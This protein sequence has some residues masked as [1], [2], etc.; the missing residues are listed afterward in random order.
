[1]RYLPIA[2]REGRD[3]EAKK[4]AI[5]RA[6]IYKCSQRR[7][8]E[9]AHPQHI[10]D[11]QFAERLCLDCKAR[12][13][14]HAPRCDSES[15]TTILV[16]SVGGDLNGVLRFFWK[17]S[18]THPCARWRLHTLPSWR[19]TGEPTQDWLRSDRLDRTFCYTKSRRNENA[20]VPVQGFRSLP[21]MPF[22]SMSETFYVVPTISNSVRSNLNPLFGM[23]IVSCPVLF[24][25]SS[26]CQCRSF[27]LW[28]CFKSF[29][30]L[31]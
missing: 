10:E 26:T 16:L 28:K 31:E 15:I 12:R 23:T 11:F 27:V 8:A 13:K 6:S 22:L 1:M 21:K 24:S 3:G 29:F 2:A 19:R 9:N 20:F 17:A 25:S 5:E 7:K 18:E 14:A 30:M 4:T